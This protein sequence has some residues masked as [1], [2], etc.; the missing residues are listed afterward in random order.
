[1]NKHCPLDIIHFLHADSTFC[2]TRN[3]ISLFGVLLLITFIVDCQD[4]KKNMTWKVCRTS[5]R[6][7]L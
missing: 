7:Y 6:L 4:T 1:M 2:T 3:S 5:L